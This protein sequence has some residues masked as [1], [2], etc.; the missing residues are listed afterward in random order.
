MTIH[1]FGAYYGLTISMILSYKTKPLS[2]PESNYI[3]NIIAMVGTLFLWL[4]WPSFNFGAFSQTPY[5]Q[6]QIVANTLLS[7][8]GSCVATLVFSGLL[9][10]K[11]EMEDIMNATLAGGVV[12]GAPC[13]ILYLPGV[14]LAI[15]AIAGSIS[16]ISFK[17]LAPWLN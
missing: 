8:T 10:H 2:K 7:L 13:G 9:G 6:S 4:F 11:F 15:G 5:E 14:A 3:S 17:R 1:S 12:I 16:T